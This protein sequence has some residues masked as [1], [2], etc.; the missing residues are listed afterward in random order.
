MKIIRLVLFLNPCSLLSLDSGLSFNAFCIH[1]LEIQL[2][3]SME[4]VISRFPHIAEKIFEELDNHHFIQSKVISPSWNNFME[5]SKFSYFRLIETSTNC[6]TKAMKKILKKTNLD[7]T[8]QLASDV[9]KLYNKLQKKKVLEQTEDYLVID[10]FLTLFHVAAKH[11]SLSVCQLMID[12]IED[13]HPNSGKSSCCQ[14][15]LHFAA[16]HGH[17]KICQLILE[18][19]EKI[20]QLILDKD[21]K[22]FQLILEKDIDE[23]KFVIPKHLD[24]MGNNPLHLAAENGHLSVCKLFIRWIEKVYPEGIEYTN[25]EN[26]CGSTP[27]HLAAENG[28]LSV[29]Q[30]L[31]GKVENKNIEEGSGLTPLGCAARKGHSAVCHLLIDNFVDVNIRDMY[32]QTALHFA[33]ENNLLSVCK[34]LLEICFEDDPEDDDG[35]TPFNLAAKSGHLNVCKLFSDSGPSFK[36]STQLVAVSNSKILQDGPS[37]KIKLA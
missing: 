9:S 27:L 5:G 11:G 6:S 37:K 3:T 4:V 13:I 34:K 7:D 17:F 23:N 25:A 32:G 8:I 33:A 26:A 19:D 10:P 16:E 30:F 35:N 20:S 29:C 21:E 14:T 24:S 1:L 18:K 15:P 22:I 31:I 28:H 12:S 36:Y 2:E